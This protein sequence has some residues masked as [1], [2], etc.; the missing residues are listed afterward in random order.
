MNNTDTREDTEVIDL[1]EF[2]FAP[3]CESH[4]C[5]VDL[6]KPTHAADWVI[7]LSCGCSMLWCNERFIRGSEWY[8]KV[9]FHVGWC[10]VC[11]YGRNDDSINLTVVAWSPVRGS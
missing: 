5:M 7:L 4:Y 9:G 1:T 10:S 8:R 2:E 6:G 3:P 11:G